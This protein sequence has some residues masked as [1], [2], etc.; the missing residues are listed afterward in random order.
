MLG[1]GK[2]RTVL[3]AKEEGIHMLNNDFRGPVSI[4]DAAPGS[5]CEWCGKPARY[6]LVVTGGKHHNEEGRFCS[7]CGEAF[8]LAVAESLSRVL[9]AE[10]R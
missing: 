3:T 6:Q 7:T 10:T 2:K 9:T 4:D 1:A 5:Y 8:I